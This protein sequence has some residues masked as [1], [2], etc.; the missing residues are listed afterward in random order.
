MTIARRV[1]ATR[2]LGLL[3]SL[4][5][6]V[7]VAACSNDDTQPTAAVAS[8]NGLDDAGSADAV[9]A[10]AR[11]P[12]AAPIDAGPAPAEA[13]ILAQD[14]TRSPYTGPAPVDG[15]A[16]SLPSGATYW[17]GPQKCSDAHCSCS[18]SSGWSCEVY[19]C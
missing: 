8:A 9:D 7:S 4:A 15:Q 1:G 11:A 6:L 12:G 19:L 18:T 17:S 14:G 3:V 10:D 5:C 2:A 16:C 13:Y